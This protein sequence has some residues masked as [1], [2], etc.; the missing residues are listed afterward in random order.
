MPDWRIVLTGSFIGSFMGYREAHIAD[1]IARRRQERRERC[2]EEHIVRQDDHARRTQDYIHNLSLGSRTKGGRLTVRRACRSLSRRTRSS[3][4]VRRGV[5]NYASLVADFPAIPGSEEHLWRLRAL[6]DSELAH[7]TFETLL[8]ELLTRIRELLRADTAAVLLLEETT[9]ELVATAAKGIE[10]EV[11]QGVRLPVGKGFAGRIAESGKPVVLDEVDHGK[12]LNP[13]LLRRGIRSMLG[14]PL[15]VA[16]SVVGVLHVGT[17]HPRQFTDQDIELLRFAADRVALAVHAQ[18]QLE[19]RVIAEALQRG[20]RPHRFPHVDGFEI[21]GY[22]RPAHPG[23]IGGDWYDVFVLPS[24]S[25]CVVVGDIAGRGLQAALRMARL[26]TAVRAMAFVEETPSGI[27]SLMKDFLQHFEPDA[28]ATILVGVIT[29]DGTMRYA[30]AGHMPPLVVEPQTGA[31][32]VD[33]AAEPPLCS[34]AFSR[35]RD[36]FLTLDPG[37]ILLLYT[38]GLVERRGQSLDRGLEALRQAAE[39]PWNSLEM[40]CGRLLS[41][42][43]PA[44]QSE[45]DVAV[46]GLRYR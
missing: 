42:E 45:D 35:Y 14:V 41:T 30:N 26:R 34:V 21:A 7:L 6:T 1:E 32:L 31:R 10:E 2:L 5:T 29:A 13:L 11:E 20:L 23:M 22:Y 25:L 12:V 18:R 37:S 3:S 40:L 19:Q 39:T 43:Q 28:M 9:N 16:G 38:D 44:A 27:V 8:D 15:I 24:R 46:L 33:E 17:L 4:A 36:R